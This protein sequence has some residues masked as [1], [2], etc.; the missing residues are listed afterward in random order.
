MVKKIFE[1]YAIRIQRSATR[2]QSTSL[3]TIELHQDT[4]TAVVFQGIVLAQ[5][6]GHWR[7][8][9]GDRAYRLLS[10]MVEGW[11]TELRVGIRSWIT[12]SGPGKSFI[13]ARV[14]A[15]VASARILGISGGE[16]SDAAKALS[17]AVTQASEVPARD[18]ATGW[19]HLRE[20]AQ[21]SR[22]T[23][24]E[25]LL[26][27]A[28][29]RQGS[30]APQALD[31]EFLLPA[32]RNFLKSWDLGPAAP[33]D[34]LAERYLR[35]LE[36]S[37]RTDLRVEKEQLARNVIRAR[38]LL[39]EGLSA[40]ELGD[41]LLKAGE[42]AVTESAF[43]PSSEIE[44]FRNEM[45]SLKTMSLMPVREAE[46]LVE[47]DWS[48]NLG[49]ALSRLAALDRA[50]LQRLLELLTVTR[51]RLQQTAGQL[52]SRLQDVGDAGSVAQEV[53]RLLDQFAELT[54]G[55]AH[56]A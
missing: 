33:D 4:Q 17:A 55:R 51:S 11:A 42:A 19:A 26:A 10:N 14:A 13:E 37:I 29:V 30:G 47:A 22:E 50:K 28:A 27:V 39:P 43:R 40:R 25:E 9:D 31:V 12:K 2:R 46:E 52:D 3:L 45:S 35:A 16:S 24:R 18:Q 8:P 49:W 54:G 21:T 1:P 41:D 23:L 20:R 38:E 48:A 5:H 36:G 32:V 6:H 44:V 7:F 53:G 34:S 15:L 56:D